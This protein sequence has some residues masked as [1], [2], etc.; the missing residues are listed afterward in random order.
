M[1][2]ADG[3]L[4]T[5]AK[6]SSQWKTKIKRECLK[7]WTQ[8]AEV[9]QT[10]KDSKIFVPNTPIE[11]QAKFYDW[12]KDNVDYPVRSERVDLSLIT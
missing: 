2:R 7:I 9:M 1:G 8:D 11:K 10:W 3:L 12:V 4:Y 6:I 5:N